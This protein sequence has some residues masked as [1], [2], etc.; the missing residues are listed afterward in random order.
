MRT[1]K[2]RAKYFADGMTWIYGD[3]IHKRTDKD[4]VL[5]QDANGLGSDCIPE[6]ICQ[7]VSSHSADYEEI[8]EGDII[9]EEESKRRYVVVFDDGAFR[10]ATKKQK[11]SLDDGVHPL[12]GDYCELPILAEELM[13]APFHIIGN[14]FDNPDKL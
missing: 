8:F 13:C 4:C 11:E 10:L 1:I 5:I 2:F 7:Y 12:M 3:L 9:E 14:I 6:T